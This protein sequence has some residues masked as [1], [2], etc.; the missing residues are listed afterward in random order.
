[1]ANLG[2]FNGG[3]FKGLIIADKINV[4]AQ[5][6]GAIFGFGNA[7]DGVTLD[8][9]TGTPNIKYSKCALDRYVRQAFPYLIV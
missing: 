7:A 8:D 5:I 3:T 1:M 6:V 4:N 2:N 9:V